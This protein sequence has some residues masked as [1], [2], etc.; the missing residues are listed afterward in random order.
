[1]TSDSAFDLANLGDSALSM[2]A[3]LSPSIPWANRFNE[4]YKGLPFGPYLDASRPRRQRTLT[5]PTAL[6][7]RSI[8]SRLP[9]IS[10]PR[11][12]QRTLEQDQCSLIS[13]LPFDVRMI[14]Y[15]M[16]LGGMVFHLQAQNKDSR[17]LLWICNQPGRIDDPN[18]QCEQLSSQRP[19]SAP[20]QDY[21][22]A[23][24]LLPLLVTCRRIYSEAV[25]VLYRANTLE[26]TQHFAAFR[27]LKMMIPQQRLQS[28][29]HLRIKM[30]IPHHPVLNNRSRRDWQRLFRFFS[31][32]MSGL[33]DLYLKLWPLEPVQVRIRATADTDKEALDWV[34]PML[35]TAL[36]GDRVREFKFEIDTAGVKHDLE[37][38]FKQVVGE[39][40]NASHDRNVEI[41]CVAVH[42]R[43]RLSLGDG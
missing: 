2:L 13:K 35:V 27:F 34:R 15:E 33:Q 6:N 29:R 21:R 12:E 23:T 38:I 20:R 14:I 5:D 28:I 17:I 26:F 8:W 22:E 32:D 24:G 43:I 31:T 30:R 25:E 41:A 7:Q 3:Q 19:S 1:M 10:S 40:E 42:R 36:G 11:P 37:A 16:V 39:N 9:L 18:H 4:V